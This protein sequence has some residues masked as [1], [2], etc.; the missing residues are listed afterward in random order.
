MR[1]IHDTLHLLFPTPFGRMALVWMETGDAP[2]VCRVVLPNE[3]REAERILLEGFPRSV[4]GTH[5]DMEALA[6]EINRFLH[7]EDISFGMDRLRLERCSP[8]QQQVLRFEH[9]VPRGR[10]TSYRRIAQ[11]LGKPRGARAVGGAL[12]GNPFPILVPCHR[13]IRSDGSLGGFQGGP[14]MKRA[15]LTLEGIAFAP[16]GKVLIP[17]FY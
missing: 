14:T 11:E 8:F 6:L 2:A 17:R 1:I 15:L 4:P 9:G 5:G 7:G 3:R 12:A 10:V 13:A 16:N